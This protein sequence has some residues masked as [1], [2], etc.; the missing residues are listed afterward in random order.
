MRAIIFTLL[1]VISL[2]IQAQ[3]SSRTFQINT[4]L[5]RSE[6]G[7]VMTDMSKNG[8]APALSVAAP[9]P[10]PVAGKSGSGAGPDR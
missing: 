3:E 7:M 1:T 5:P 9:A 4:P 10:P 2:S 8:N 6:P